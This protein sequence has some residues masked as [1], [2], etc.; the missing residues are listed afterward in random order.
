MP[1]PLRIQC[2]CEVIMTSSIL[3]GLHS[4]K[5]AILLSGD[6]LIIRNIGKK[7]VTV[8]VY[9]IQGRRVAHDEFR[10]SERIVRCNKIESLANGIYIY[11]I[12]IGERVFNRRFIV[13]K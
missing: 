3:S 4:V 5:N 1:S 11:K 6:G 12:K 2:K 7:P 9:D 10:A 13:S 8:A